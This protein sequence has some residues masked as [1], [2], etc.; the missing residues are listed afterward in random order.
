M[1]VNFEVPYLKYVANGVSTVFTYDWSSGDP[2]DIYVQIDGVLAREGIE[3]ELENW[4]EYEGGDIVFSAPPAAGTVIF[5]YRDTPVT[6]QVA[7]E[8]GKP[9]PA[10][11]HERQMDKDT[12][13]LQE[14]IEAG[15]AAGGV[16]DLSAD[17]Q[18][19][20][21]D[22]INSSGTDAR[23]VPWTVDGLASGVAIGE[24]VPY[25]STPPVDG[26]ATTKHDGY[27][28]WWLDAPA[29]GGGDQM[30]TL[31]TSPIVVNSEE[32]A[33]DPARAELFYDASAGTVGYG[34]D[35]LFPLLSPV[36]VEDEAFATPIVP[37]GSYLIQLELV[38]G[39]T[40]LG[41]AVDTWTDANADVDWYLTSGTFYGKLHIAPDD[42]LGAPVD[43]FKISRYV[44][45]S[46]V[47]S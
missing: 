39:D 1:T 23:I 17:Q 5:I 35:Q 33:P 21:T 4:K 14:I 2:D 28:W 12:R 43:A 30:I 13:I 7:Y 31:P 25:E 34:Y 22:I 41:D 32:T 9:F 45:L 42:G 10:E 29:D 47:S 11:T 16:V 19:E 20:Y 46:A 24:V 40:P 6:Q 36:W 37:S 44:T 18:P 3:Y 26:A 38:S 15:R 27:L 8:E